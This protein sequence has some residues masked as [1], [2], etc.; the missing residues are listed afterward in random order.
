MTYINNYDREKIRKQLHYI[1]Y[2]RGL[3][4][5]ENIFKDPNEQEDKIHLYYIIRHIF[6][7]P[8]RTWFELV[9]GNKINISVRR[10]VFKN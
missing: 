3:P 5:L 7:E 10:F 9:F 1:L 4:P 6:G 8:I 2:F